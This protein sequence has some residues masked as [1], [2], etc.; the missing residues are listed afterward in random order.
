M[1]CKQDI[2]NYLLVYWG[3]GN[4]ETEYDANGIEEVTDARNGGA[5]DDIFAILIDDY[6]E[7]TNGIAYSATLQ[8]ATCADIELRI[9]NRHGLRGAIGGKFIDATE[10]GE[11]VQSNYS[12]FTQVGGVYEWRKKGAEIKKEVFFDFGGDAD[13]LGLLRDACVY[14]Q[15]EW[16]CEQ[17]GEW[18]PCKVEQNSCDTDPFKEQSITL[19]LQQL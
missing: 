14:G 10:G 18:L 16:Y 7:C 19:I 11:S 1:L 17:S 8:D 13:L 2:D 6:N 5:F 12:T 3:N 9:T 15:V 4:T